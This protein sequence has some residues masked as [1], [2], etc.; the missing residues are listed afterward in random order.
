MNWIKYLN[1]QPDVEILLLF[2]LIIIVYILFYLKIDFIT[3]YIINHR[4]NY[5]NFIANLINK[6]NHLYYFIAAKFYN[7]D[8]YKIFFNKYKT[9]PSIKLESCEIE[10]KDKTLNLFIK[11]RMELS[12]IYILLMSEFNNGS[13]KYLIDSNTNIL[14]IEVIY[15]CRYSVKKFIFQHDFKLAKSN[16][17]YYYNKIRNLNR[18]FDDDHYF[19]A[20]CEHI[21]IIISIE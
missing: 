16:P 18:K 13:L 2:I 7:D 9:N 17:N 5:V 19:Y 14:G 21:N 6:F 3:T 4:Y 15:L 10:L 11:H 20:D 12:N 1:L 8:S